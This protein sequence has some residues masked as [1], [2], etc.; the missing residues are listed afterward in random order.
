MCFSPCLC[1]V[2]FT[3]FLSVL[4][5]LF[6]SHR[7][8]MSNNSLDLSR[9]LNAFVYNYALLLPSSLFIFHFQAYHLQWNRYK[10]KEE[11]PIA[12]RVITRLLEYMSTGN[13]I[14][15][16][17]S[18]SNT[19]FVDMESL[20]VCVVHFEWIYI[21][22]LIA[23][24]FLYNFAYSLSSTLLLFYFFVCGYF[25]VFCYLTCFNLLYTTIFKHSNHRTLQMIA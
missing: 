16:N 13:G 5:V 17:C 15:S 19:Y 10:G 21:E 12:I 3:S 11:E 22:L 6:C 8:S 23:L 20:F 14:H 24:Y 18:L 1:N 2:F 25:Q 7:C 9:K 4:N